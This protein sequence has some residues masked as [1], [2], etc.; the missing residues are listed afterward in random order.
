MDE[1]PSDIQVLSQI[2]AKAD[3][4]FAIAATAAQVKAAVQTHPPD[5]IVLDQELAARHDWQVGQ[6]WQAE[7]TIAAVPIIMI[8]S[9]VDQRAAAF[10]WGASD[11]LL[12]PWQATEVL[13]KIKFHL[14]CQQNRQ[15]LAHSVPPG[16]RQTQEQ[17]QQ[18]VRDRKRLERA[19]RESEARFRTIFEQTALGINLADLSGRFIRV[20]QW[21]C[22]LLGYTEAELLERTFHQITHPDDL[23]RQQQPQAQL[24]AGEIDSFTL[25]KR[26]LRRDGTVIWVSVTVSSVQDADGNRI[27]DL[28]I[29][30]NI[31]DRKQAEAALRQSESKHRVLINALPDLIMRMSGDGIYLD[32]FPTR[33]FQVLG[34][35]ALVGKQIYA[36]GLPP[37][38]ADLRLR[39]IQQALHTGELQVYEQELAVNGDM[40]TEEVRIAVCGEQEVLVIVRD[41]TDRRQLEQQL[42]STQQTLQTLVESTASVTGE[43]FFPALAQQIARALQVSHVIVSRTHH[44]W[45]ETL[46]C[47]ANGTLLSNF[48]Y[49]IAHTPCEITLTNGIYYCD[50]QVQARFPQDQDLGH[51]NAE[52]YF[53]IALKNSGGQVIGLLCVISQQPI[54]NL[55]Q[56]ETIL[57]IFAARAA[58]ELER[59]QVLESLHQL[60][61]EL[62]MRVQQRTQD[63][64]KSQQAW[65]ESEAYR[66][67]LFETAPIGLVLCQ[68]DGSLVDV[69]PAFAEMIGRSI[70]ETLTLTYF[71]I[72]PERYAAAEQVQL[73]TLRSTGRYGPYEK[74]YI[75]KEGHLVPVQLSGI[76][77]ERD[78]EPFIWSGVT[79][80]SALKQ[81]EAALRDSEERLRLALVAAN[82]GLYDLN[83]QTGEAVVS[84]EYAT[85][86]EYDPATFH[87][88]NAK[89]IARLH[90]DDQESVANIYRAYVSG[91]ISDYVVEFRQR[92][93]SG[94]WKWILSLGKIVAWD[95]AGQPLRMLGTH[96]DISDRKAA[97]AA[98]RRANAE[99]EMRVEAR[100]AELR[101]AKEAAESANRA[102]S[103]FLANMSHELRTPLNAILGFSQLMVRDTAIGEQHR[104]NL[105]IINRSGEHLLN[106]INDILEMSKIEAGQVN[107]TPTDF[108]LYSLLDSL[109]EMFR[110]RAETKGVQLTLDRDGH[111]PRYIH[112]DDNKLRQILINLLGNAVKF[113]PTG[114]VILRVRRLTP[115]PAHDRVE[116][117]ISYTLVFEVKDTGIGIPTEAVD[118][119]FNPFVQANPGHRT[120]DGTGLGLAISRQ[121]V[122]LLGGD[123]TIESQV[124]QGTT[125]RFT[126]QA[127]CAQ[128]TPDLDVLVCRQV[129]GLAPNQP[130]YRLLVV[131]DN[132]PSRK[133]LMSLLQPLGFD[134]QTVVN[135]REAIAM[136]QRWHPHLIWM[137]M[138]M[139]ELDGYEATRQIRA[140]EA[141]QPPYLQP[142]VII[143]L[144]ASA[145]E[146]QRA[147][148]LAVGCNDFIRKPFQIETLLEKMAEYLGVQYLY[149]EEP[150]HLVANP[151]DS[152]HS[153]VRLPPYSLTPQA[154]QVMPVEWIKLVHAAT[155]ALE[156]DQ[157]LNL[158]QQIP[159]AH[160]AL[161][162]ALQERIQEFDFHQ[163]FELTNSA[164][165]DLELS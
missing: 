86:L 76:V 58:A 143:A 73:Q 116:R 16:I 151:P 111:L 109:T 112:T 39:R 149:A 126:V 164:L 75:H 81:V 134:V 21:F 30:E 97:E 44:Q 92:T 127:S 1:Q 114:E 106:L 96:T 27:A 17:F 72:T 147:R 122:Y 119:L 60:N 130:T 105:G 110:L 70:E 45:L 67:I 162:K 3:V 23:Q 38:L 98:L 153:S 28:A 64:F 132:L 79:N 117:N 49:A 82:Q 93:R 103:A 145:F 163:V 80:I 157:L 41:V 66:R 22:R 160:P 83:L 32:F 18:D 57:R 150:A 55:P 90:P 139:P 68:M 155:I 4:G 47:F 2:L 121:Y 43:A 78:G 154:L 141:V 20:N 136:W 125:V 54:A 165:K 140:I 107:F 128:A 135:G 99:L 24:L 138:R 65:Q 53:G 94:N 77:I 29:V 124:G 74:E 11:Y 118:T 48:T 144:T 158:I 5:L 161:A 15:F 101:Q 10:Q 33:T 102:K 13:T 50:R 26:Y 52:S 129:V 156:P 19:L 88:T 148:I 159:A 7:P 95:E 8:L 63:L 14:Q 131:E 59:L 36:G 40:R 42:Q 31:S 137:D 87:E 100:T 56:A 71:D 120:Q 69:N 108:D 62:E 89:W 142:T 34:D 84:L 113:T 51:L 9:G 6:Q 37:H 146:E 91:E 115:S 85:M 35:A 152:S 12:K 123:I 46:A 25:E 61:E 133:L 104:E